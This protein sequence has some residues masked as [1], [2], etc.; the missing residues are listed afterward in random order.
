MNMQQ[1][2]DLRASYEG[3]C[4]CCGQHG[5]DDVI[6]VVDECARLMDVPPGQWAV[7]IVRARIRNA[8]GD[9]D[10]NPYVPPNIP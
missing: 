9:P 1:L 3:G 4:G 8:G 10:T 2:A 7:E 6:E 5:F